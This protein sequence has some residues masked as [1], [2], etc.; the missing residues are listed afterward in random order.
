MSV[1]KRNWRGDRIEDIKNQP[2]FK[3]I[4]KNLTLNSLYREQKGGKSPRHNST[5][6]S[7]EKSLS[8]DHRNI[9]KRTPKRTLDLSSTEYGFFIKKNAPSHHHTDSSK[10]EEPYSK[11][12]LPTSKLN[13]ENRNT[14]FLDRSALTSRGGR[15]NRLMISL[16]NQRTIE[17]LKYSLH[18]SSSRSQSKRTPK[19]LEAKSYSES[20]ESEDNNNP[21]A[22]QI[23]P[24]NDTIQDDENEFEF[25]FVTKINKTKKSTNANKKQETRLDEKSREMTAKSAI[26]NQENR[27][28]APRRAI[29]TPKSQMMMETNFRKLKGSLVNLMSRDKTNP[30]YQDSLDSTNYFMIKTCNSYQGQGLS[31]LK[32]IDDPKYL[33]PRDESPATT[34]IENSVSPKNKISSMTIKNRSQILHVQGSKV[35]GVF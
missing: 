1:S 4:Q 12:K 35:K 17:A 8:Q 29:V 14:I 31:S 21:A 33:S 25:N 23:L 9:T 22:T 3:N 15:K 2:L 19:D 26:R 30:Y 5:D 28:E 16:D 7:L 6:N 32:V 34:K 10:I 27:R 24:A 18:P 11:Y 20:D 13:L